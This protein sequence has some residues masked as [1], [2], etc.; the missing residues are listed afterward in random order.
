MSVAR[1]VFDSLEGAWTIRRK[2]TSAMPGYPTGFLQGTA[3]FFQ[4]PPTATAFD[5]EYLYV[6]QGE[7]H[8]D[9]GPKMQASRMYVYR[10][11]AHNDQISTWFVKDDGMTVDYL[12]NELQHDPSRDEDDPGAFILKGDHLCVDDMYHASYKFQSP[13]DDMIFNVTYKVQGPKKDYSHDTMY[14]RS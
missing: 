11:H 6:E 3:N 1:K 13:K 12:F 4:R 10:Y 8:P 2:L 14:I 9:G 7:L 5:A